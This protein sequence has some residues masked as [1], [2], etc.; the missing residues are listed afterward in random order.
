M[1]DGIDGTRGGFEPQETG[2]GNWICEPCHIG[3]YTGE[4]REPVLRLVGVEKTLDGKKVLDGVTLEIPRGQITAIIGLSGAGK[5]LLLKHM[6]GLMKPDRGQVLL[7]GVDINRLTRQELYEVRKRFGMLFQSG[8]LFDSM[9]VFENV[10]FPLREK[11]D[12]PEG[13]IREK[14]GGILRKVGLEKAEE[15]FPD[16]LSG[17]M[18]RRVALAR[19]VVTD[20]EIILFDEPTTGLDPI[21]RNSILHLICRTYHEH[22]FTMVMISHDLPDIFQRCQHVAVVHDGKVVEVGT[23][24]EIQNSADPLV[25]QLVEG[26]ITGPVQLM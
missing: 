14:V 11:T 22:H 6:I 25:R 18:V 20:P 21:I 10:A 24:E 15:K 16:E 12:M 13:E 1:R 2:G 19:A 7:D 3:P 4:K 23:P 5:S 17:G 9:T 26:D 8:A